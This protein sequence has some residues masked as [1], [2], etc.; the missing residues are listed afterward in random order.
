MS[1]EE[2]L[3]I[4]GITKEE[5]GCADDNTAIHELFENSHDSNPA[6]FLKVFAEQLELNKLISRSKKWETLDSKI[7]AFYYD[8]DGNEIEE[9]EG[10]GLV[11]IGECAASAF[12]Y[13]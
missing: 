13:L 9:S 11:G 10:D 12:G 2:L 1:N 5:L 3:N 7:H 8:K 6:S 4:F